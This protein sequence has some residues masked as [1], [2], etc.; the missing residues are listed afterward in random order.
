MNL[1]LKSR[2]A[3]VIAASSGLGAACAEALSGEGANVAIC[4]RDLDRIRGAAAAMEKKTGNPV[5]PIT[6]DISDLGSVEELAGRVKSELGA[7]D[8]LVT[9][10]GGPPPGDFKDLSR[11]QWEEGIS[12]VLVSVLDLCR[13]FIPSMAAKGWG[14][15]VMVT[16][17]SAKHPIDGLMVSNTLRSGLLG[18][19]RSLSREYG[20]QG[21][22]VNCVL[23][24]FMATQRL[25][26]LA[27]ERAAKA[28]ISEK[29]LRAGWEADIPLRRIADPA[30]LGDVVAFL[31]SE[32]A[33]YVT[34]SAIM[35]DGG[36]SRGLP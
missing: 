21:V 35:V 28:G 20:P 23:P 33:S 10:C 5:L 34:G 3:L 8:I 4:S 12:G 11:T 18:L 22:L 17:V 9:N 26:Q 13:A 30:E 6:A 1:N 7:P 24:G 27:A 19:A 36:Y 32:R 16:S 2:N 31:C 29:A 14:R 25:N 15:V